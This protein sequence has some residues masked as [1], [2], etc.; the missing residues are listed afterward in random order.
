MSVRHAVERQ[1][2]SFLEPLM[3]RL[4]PAGA[5]ITGLAQWGRDPR[6][7]HL[8]A[9]ARSLWASV[10]VSKG[11][12]SF[13]HW[14]RLRSGLAA[15]T[16]P[17]HPEYWG[18]PK[19]FDQR[20]VEMAP[21]AV[22][23]LLVPEH[24]WEPLGA[25]ERRRLLDWLG[26]VEQRK[27]LGHNWQFFRVINDLARR[28]L[29]VTID[30]TAH[31]LALD[32]LCAR[33]ME[34]GW[35]NDGAIGSDRPVAD[36]YSVFVFHVLAIV[37][38]TSGIGDPEISR[39]FLDHA[40]VF[41]QQHR[42]WFAADGTA[43][44]YGRSMGYRMAQSA[45]WAILPMADLEVLPW[46]DVR[47]L[48]QRS[49]RAWTT[50]PIF[51][52][53]GLLSIGYWNA[54]PRVVEGYFSAGSPYWAGLAFMALAAP[55]EHPFWTAPESEPVIDSRTHVQT[56][57]GFVMS[58]DGTSVQAVSSGRGAGKRKKTFGGHYS[59]FAYSTHF[60][61]TLESNDPWRRPVSDST[62]AF[63]SRVRWRFV[64]P[65]DNS[66]I[67]GHI[68]LRRCS[69]WPGVTVETAMWGESPWHVRLHFVHTRRRLQMAEFGFA[70]PHIDEELPECSRD[71]PS[72]SM[73]VTSANGRVGIVDLD[74][75]GSSGVDVIV[76]SQALAG[77][78]CSIPSVDRILRPGTHCFSTA[79]YARVADSASA[80]S[81]LPV[82]GRDLRTSTNEHVERVRALL[83]RVF[84][85][86]V[87]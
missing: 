11:G 2:I 46:G 21:I 85:P 50:R 55:K 64:D 42:R 39:R 29:G 45:F 35:W 72:G 79:V 10:A 18:A 6:R 53:D 14:D 63:R 59:K 4:S 80:H 78:P 83:D 20:L 19:D 7:S 28:S 30:D 1:A 66:A 8:E 33:M 25:L 75:E 60:P 44:A 71:S 15:G 51:E 67:D 3:A 43:L 12:G 58:T 13:G 49:L 52:P 61:F 68:A 73:W 56:G 27:V 5:C 26:S 86:S 48:Y 23:L 41:A 22:A 54:N 77:V 36:W 32:S 65:P 31:R 84:G 82:L 69:V 62:M 34:D 40:T 38:A 47:S 24:L 74:G 70:L 87:P 76:S 81:A 16:D 17:T 37:Y 9:F 57:P